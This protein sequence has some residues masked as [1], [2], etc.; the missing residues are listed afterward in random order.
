MA[1]VRI[2]ATKDGKLM[3]WNDRIDSSYEN[4]NLVYDTVTLAVYYKFVEQNHRSMT[5]PYLGYMCPYLGSNLR[6]CKF[7]DGKIV[8]G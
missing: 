1:L 3:S 4:T 8:E 7:I 2:I 6:F 5:P